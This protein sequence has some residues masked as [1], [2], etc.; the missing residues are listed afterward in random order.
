MYSPDKFKTVIPPQD[1]TCSNDKLQRLAAG[2]RQA[3]AWV[4]KNCCQKVYEYALMITNNQQMS[5]DVVHD[6]FIKLWINKE[7]L[8]SVQNFNGYLYRLYRNLLLDK[9]K[10]HQREINVR[11][12]YCIDDSI[13]I[14]NANDI[15]IIKEQ[16]QLMENAIKQLPKQQQIVYRLRREHGWK[17]DK[18][19]RELEIS[20]FTVKCHLQKA[21]GQLRIKCAGLQH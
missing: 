17:H 20:P 4:Y 19:A 15:M 8:K 14:T 1:I 10:S 3:F 6:V 16:E 21:I 9:L 18:I 7:K 5:E 2:D 11:K 13:N 12:N